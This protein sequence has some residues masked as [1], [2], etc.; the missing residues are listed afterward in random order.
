MGQKANPMRNGA[1]AKCFLGLSLLQNL[2]SVGKGT[3]ASVDQGADHW[4]MRDELGLHASLKKKMLFS[5]P[6]IYP[7]NVGGEC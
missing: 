4:D 5:F 2:F 7:S 1:E 6:G 3:L